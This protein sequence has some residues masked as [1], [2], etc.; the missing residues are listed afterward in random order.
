MYFKAELELGKFLI[1]SGV[2]DRGD[3][4]DVDH[5]RASLML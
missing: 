2:R 3:L 1:M 4:A 5:L